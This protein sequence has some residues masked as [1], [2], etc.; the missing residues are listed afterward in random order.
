MN[1]GLSGS[2]LSSRSIVTTVQV[3][4][5]SALIG[6][7]IGVVRGSGDFFL[8]EVLMG[9]L[10]GLVIGVGCSFLEFQFL[11]NARLRFTRRLPPVLLM[12]LRAVS[13]SVV[14]IVGLA[15]PGLLTAAPPLWRDPEF[16]EVF[17]IS[18]VVAFIISTGVEVTRLLGSEATLALVT[19]RYNRARLEE[20]V[21]LF[22]DVVGSTALAE[23]IGVLRFHDFLR[24]VSQDLAEPVELARGD[25]YKYVG[26]AVIVTWPLARGVRKA[27]CLQCADR[28]HRAL[29][30]RSEAYLQ[31]Y[32][33]E[34]K[35][36]VA[37]HCGAVAAGEVGDWKKEVAL[38]GDTMN[39][40]ARIE[41]AA[42][43]FGARIA[44]SEQLVRLLPESSR[45]TLR[46]LPD[47][48]AAGKQERLVLWTSDQ[49]I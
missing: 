3:G 20:R 39:T 14:I 19:G 8:I 48:D 11:S 5:S 49:A 33:A 29:R 12:V 36:R 27:A 43:H 31:R 34:A 38:L 13:Y 45:N 46:R 22:A 37:I 17:V 42:K 26:D 9:G 10:V 28:M 41:A 7:L 35:L 24:D 18:A 1:T 25:V 21:V 47:Y 6:I 32:G 15:L 40:T 4:I 16:A 44:L 2:A 30:E 23:R